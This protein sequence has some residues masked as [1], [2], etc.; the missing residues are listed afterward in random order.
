M[1]DSL[2]RSE[3]PHPNLYR[4]TILLLTA[5]GTLIACTP[6]KPTQTIE[7]SPEPC[8]TLTPVAVTYQGLALPTPKPVPSP[9]PDPS[10]SGPFIQMQP[11][12]VWLIAGDEAVLATIGSYEYYRCGLLEHGDALPPQALGGL[13]ATASLPVRARAEIVVGSTAII[14]FQ[15]AIQPWSGLP[16]SAFDPL[17]GR[18]LRA[19]GRR[20]GDIKVYVL[21]P[22][23]VDD[24][25]LAVFITYDVGPGYPGA[26]ANYLWRLNPAD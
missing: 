20:E 11:P 10:H 24:Q 23:D 18:K 12:P 17:S 16:E 21:E 2:M 5:L 19:E 13:L 9:P 1:E 15:A 3:C 6:S 26:G 8:P 4:W 14:K 22:I 25:L 7:P